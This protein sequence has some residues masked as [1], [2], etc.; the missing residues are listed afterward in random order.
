MSTGR[1]ACVIPAKNEETTIAATV[2]AARE[3]P[4]VATVIVVDDGSSDGTAQHATAAG[5]IVVGHD[6]NR[7]KAA[8]IESGVN[9]L[10]VLEQRDNLPE[11]TAILLLDA[12]LGESAAGAAPL[13]GPVVSGAAAL[14][15]GVLPAQTTDD[16]SPAGGHGIVLNTARRGIEELSGFSARAPLSGQRCITRRAFELASPLAAGFGI[17]VG[18]TIDVV[19]AGLTVQEIDVDLQHRATGNDLAGQLHRAKQL[20]DVTRALTAR[21]LIGQ[22]TGELRSHPTVSGL[23]D[24]LRGR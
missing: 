17:E 19:R 10:G 16:G 1:V 15:I 6:R 11:A 14:T 2:A 23:L 18:M 9:A 4:Q 8:A 22:T 3:L 13:I 5:A 20:K 24:R 12:D 7:G 21:G